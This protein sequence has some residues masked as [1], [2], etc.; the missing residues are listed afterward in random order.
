LLSLAGAIVLSFVGAG[1]MVPG[2]S[3]PVQAIMAPTSATVEQASRTP[4]TGEREP[5]R[6]SICKPDRTS[7]RKPDRTSIIKLDRTDFHRFASGT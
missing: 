3:A 7:I 1:F 4:R 6:T 5:D 2:P